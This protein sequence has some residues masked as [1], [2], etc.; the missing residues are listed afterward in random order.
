[1]AAKRERRAKRLAERADRLAI[2]SHGAA[3]GSRR[4]QRMRSRLV[5]PL[6][7]EPCTCRHSPAAT[8]NDSPVKSRRVPRRHSRS[9]ASSIG[10]RRTSELWRGATE[11]IDA[12]QQCR[13]RA[14]SPTKA[15]GGFRPRSVI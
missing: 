4:P 1:M 11:K 14:D 9:V 12:G 5:L 7:F 2:P 15:N 10:R 13:L 3:L 8:W 6:P